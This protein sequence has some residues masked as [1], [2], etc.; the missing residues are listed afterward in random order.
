[1]GAAMAKSMKVGSEFDVDD[2]LEKCCKLIGGKLLSTNE[3]HREDIEMR[4]PEVWRWD[5]L[6]RKAVRRSRRAVTTDHLLGPLEVSYNK[7][8]VKRRR[9]VDTSGPV[10]KPVV[11]RTDEV[12]VSANETTAQV[13]E[14][15]KRLMQV[16][17]REGVNLFRFVINPHSF[18]DTVENL[19]YVS[20]LIR[21]G[22]AALD[23]ENEK[24]EPMLFSCES[25][26]KE[27]HDNGVRRR[28][29]VLE[30]DMP[31]WRQLIE[32]YDIRT[33]MIESRKP[34]QT[35][36]TDTWQKTAPTTTQTSR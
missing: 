21:D 33:S 13:K 35:A 11:M 17:G 34:D 12:A 36:N 16:G 25:A 14:I 6:G 26:T 19:F 2:F 10:A 1:M 32:E 15:N 18:S 30:L 27:D 28:Q 24:D 3:L 8:K 29:I 31:V 9:E 23:T 5:L 20:F 7:R 4:D 22:L